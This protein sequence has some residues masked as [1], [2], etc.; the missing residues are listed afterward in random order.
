[1]YRVV[2]VFIFNIT[3]FTCDLDICSQTNATLA[4]EYILR[5]VIEKII[6]KSIY[7]QSITVSLPLDTESKVW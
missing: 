3:M 2:S 4:L 7:K 5:T 1:M 6:D